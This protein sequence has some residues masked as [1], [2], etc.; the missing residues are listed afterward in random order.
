[1]KKF[2]FRLQK[3]LEFRE[4]LEGWAKDAY[5]DARSSKLE[6]ELGLLQIQ[7]KRYDVLH[8]A[9]NGIEGLRTIE[10][11]LRALDEKEFE[12]KVV[13]N[14]LANEEEKTLEEWTEKKIEL[15]ALQKMFDKQYAEWQLEMDR[16]LQGELDE[17]ALRKRAA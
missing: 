14:V 7:T 12:Q 17:W 10:Q 8:S 3:V 5:L 4:M 11:Q 16:K 13:I 15:Q 6:A 2:N 9:A 1:M